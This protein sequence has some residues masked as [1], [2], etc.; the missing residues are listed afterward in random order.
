M[1]QTKIIAAPQQK[2]SQATLDRLL[3]A[4]IL[5]LNEHGLEGAVIPRIAALAEVAP[6][7]VYRRFANKD[8]LMR[9]A[10]LHVLENSN[11][12]N[13]TGLAPA[14]QGATLAD[15]A[16]ALMRLS[17]A[18]YRQYPGLMRALTR[19]ID[20]DDDPQF[21]ATA[22]AIVADNLNLAVQCLLAHRDEIRHTDPERAL[23]FAALHAITSIEA[24]ALGPVSLWHSV[25]PASDE[26]LA[27]QLTRSFVAYL[28]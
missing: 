13:R 15:S 10:L 2:R 1:S 22:R 25:L 26:A 21:V 24:I 8:A 5:A 12:A 3:H 11:Q 23:Q 7:S 17:F 27:D 9:A 20:T 16:A 19:F 4:T 18:Q 6:A 14:L 28:T